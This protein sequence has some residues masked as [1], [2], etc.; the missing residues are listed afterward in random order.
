MSKLDEFTDSMIRAS[1]EATKEH[2]K[3]LR[4]QG[5]KLRRKTAQRAR[6][7]VGKAAVQ[8]PKYTRTPGQ[9]HKSIKRG[10]VYT[11]DGGLQIRVYSGDKIAHLIEMGW[12]PKLRNGS[13]GKKRDGKNVFEDAQTAFEDEFA[14]ASEEAIDEMIRKL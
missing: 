4:E 5:T 8:R 12:T 2:K 6:A 14:K 11:K 1:K 10:K 7:V 13:K 9:Y 3:F